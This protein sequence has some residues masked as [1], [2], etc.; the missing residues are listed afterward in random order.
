MT[1]ASLL[2]SPLCLL[3]AHMHLLPGRNWPCSTGRFWG[4]WPRRGFCA[5]F[6]LGCIVELW[7]PHPVR[8]LYPAETPG[9]EHFPASCC[10]S[11]LTSSSILFFRAGGWSL[12]PCG[13]S[14]GLA[15]GIWEGFLLFWKG[16]V[17]FLCQ[18]GSGSLKSL[19]SACQVSLWLGPGII[20]PPRNE[21]FH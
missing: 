20:L 4:F 2:K 13:M 12:T 1:A 7:C 11:G 9:T 15:E 21:S 18:L 5:V 17:S 16:D 10:L 14:S 8:G 6:L 19:P 3:S